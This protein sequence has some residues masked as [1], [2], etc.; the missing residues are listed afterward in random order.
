MSCSGFPLGS[1]ATYSIS[2]ASLVV[3]MD[4]SAWRTGTV[5][6][7]SPSRLHLSAQAEEFLMQCLLNEMEACFPGRSKR[8]RFTAEPESVEHLH[9]WLFPVRLWTRFFSILPLEFLPYEDC[10]I[11]LTRAK[12]SVPNN[13]GSPS[14]GIFC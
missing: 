13:D 3:T 4:T 8:S 14:L 7:P 12:E 11:I 9:R 10:V 5:S 1:F 6:G 2:A